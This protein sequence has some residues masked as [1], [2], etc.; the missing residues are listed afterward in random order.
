MAQSGDSLSPTDGIAIIL[1]VVGLTLPALCLIGC[2]VSCY[3]CN[4]LLRIYATILIVLLVA[5]IV[6]VYVVFS[7][8]TRFTSLIV[9]SLETLLQC[10]GETDDEGKMSS[11]ICNV[12]IMVR[13]VTAWMAR[14]I[15][16]N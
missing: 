4:I 5:Q 3:G 11:A 16:T 8:P 1:V 2:I 15:F 14:A 7:D 10:Y 6:V 12:A 13:H 9:S